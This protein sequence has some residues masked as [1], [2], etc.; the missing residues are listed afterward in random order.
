MTE[1]FEEQLVK[2]WPFSNLKHYQNDK[3]SLQMKANCVQWKVLC[4][5]CPGQIHHYLSK[6]EALGFVELYL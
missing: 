1:V 2:S 5:I 6:K 3:T 4:H